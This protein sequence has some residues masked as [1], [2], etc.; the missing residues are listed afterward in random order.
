MESSSRSS[1]E[2]RSCIDMEAMESSPV[3]GGDGGREVAKASDIAAP[4]DITARLD[5]LGLSSSM[6]PANEGRP[7][8]GEDFVLEAERGCKE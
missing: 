2:G 7:A 5:T 4:S 8:A 1:A 3:A 6:E